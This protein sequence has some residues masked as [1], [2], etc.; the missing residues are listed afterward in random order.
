MPEH[1]WLR[2]CTMCGTDDLRGWFGSPSAIADG[3]WW[4][5]SCRSES[6][7]AVCVS[8]PGSER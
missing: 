2:R 7:Q 3:P 4:C 8:V 6:W 1:A 5:P